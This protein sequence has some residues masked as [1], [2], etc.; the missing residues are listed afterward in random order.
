MPF[1][2]LATVYIPYRYAATSKTM[3]MIRDDLVPRCSSYKMCARCPPRSYTGAGGSNRKFNTLWLSQS[4]VLL[5]SKIGEQ[6]SAFR[7]EKWLSPTAAMA[8]IAREQDAATAMANIAREQDAAAA[9]ANIAREQ[10]AAAAMANIA[11]EQDAV[12]SVLG[13]LMT[14]SPL[15]LASSTLRLPSQH[16][17]FHHN[18]SIH[19]P[20]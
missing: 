16:S 11:R 6:S 18:H 19:R 15:R 12:T 20:R 14:C 17:A 4:T 1:I 8:K 2:A 10:D 13:I 3:L 7:I 9:M 5:H